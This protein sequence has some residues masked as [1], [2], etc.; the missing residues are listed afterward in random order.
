MKKPNQKTKDTLLVLAA[1]TAGFLAVSGGGFSDFAK[2]SFWWTFWDVAAWVGFVVF[3]GGWA[4]LAVKDRN[5]NK[6]EYERL[7]K[8]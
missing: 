2:T 3:A 5:Y 1:L 7:K 6:S 8:K 4:Y